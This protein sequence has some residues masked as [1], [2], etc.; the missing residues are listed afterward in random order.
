MSKWQIVTASIATALV[1]AF[2][3]YV[4]T[5]VCR[6]GCGG[7]ILTLAADAL[8]PE[9]VAPMDAQSGYTLE[10]HSAKFSGPVQ[11]RAF[12]INWDKVSLELKKSILTINGQKIGSIAEGSTIAVYEDGKV[13][14]NGSQP[15]PPQD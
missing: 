12:E 11:G 15:R 3:S 2:V 7:E 10:I 13:L 6:S 8:V 14:V 4:C 1:V 5:P 9:N